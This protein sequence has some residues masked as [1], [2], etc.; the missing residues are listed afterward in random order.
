[1]GKG[2]QQSA[3][4]KA[5]SSAGKGKQLEHLETE[6]LRKWAKAY[7]CGEAKERKDL[8]LAL[9]SHLSLS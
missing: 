5:A 1:M 6:E 9:V 2:G 3:A 4:V 8:I 7:A